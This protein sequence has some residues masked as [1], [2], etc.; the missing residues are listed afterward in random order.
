MHRHAKQRKLDS[1]DDEKM[2]R[3]CSNSVLLKR[4]A[5]HSLHQKKNISISII[6]AILSSLVY[7]IG[8]IIIGR[9]VDQYIFPEGI[10]GTNYSGLVFFMT[11]FLVIQVV[12][13]F[14]ENVQS[15]FMSL[16][17]QN[18]IYKLKEIAFKKLQDI[19][20]SYYSKTH[21]GTIIS[22]LTNDIDII[23]EFLSGQ[24]PVLVAGAI[25]IIGVLIVMFTINVELALASSIMLPLI[26]ILIASLQGRIQRSWIKSRV[27]MARVTSKLSESISGMKLIQ[28][29][30]S[31]RGN[32]QDFDQINYINRDANLEAARCTS[33]L[34]PGTQIVQSIGIASVFVVGTLLIFGNEISLGVLVTFYIW[35]NILFRPVQHLI[36]SY[37]MYESAMTALDRVFQIY[38]EP[39]N[40]TESAKPIQLSN[41]KGSIEFRN[42]TFG[43]NS[44]EPVL[45][46]I[47]LNIHSGEMVALI[48]AT[49]AGKSTMANLLYRF[50]DPNYG[51]VLIDGHDVKNLSFATYRKKMA[52]VLQDPFLF[53]T[54]VFENIRYGR[55]D[56]TDDEVIK[57]SKLIGVDEFV[58]K[59][60]D[61]Y[62]TLVQEDS[63]NLSGGQKQ[64]ISLARTILADPKIVILDEAMSKVDP[65]S[66]RVIQDALK[67]VFS[68][69]TSLVIAHRLST[70]R[71][72]NRII[73][74]DKGRIIEE[75][76]HIELLNKGRLY[77]KL[78]EMQFHGKT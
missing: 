60:P 67:I 34:V 19:Q 53:S 24:I 65:H 51:Q 17:G 63:T 74:F 15:Y 36:L 70:I 30:A 42:I 22:R 12:N 50:Y 37:G 11:I 20:L 31:E 8:P 58:T 71:I 4:L 64:L 41:I 16:A 45:K 18:I 72:A 32:E 13:Y 59:F 39:I 7:I 47:N 2:I 28:S 33:I 77:P 62:Q 23:D 6:S 66:E 25:T 73:V 57:V 5:K 54:S 46:K 69:R 14:A 78:Y 29:F 44:D 1:V 40:I 10:V 35:L 38:D 49:G 9:S 68:G 3:S 61:G 52:F 76:T 43:Y 75:G 55:L 56:A 27:S 21:S 26:A 48:G